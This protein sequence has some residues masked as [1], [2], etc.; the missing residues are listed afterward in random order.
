[1]TQQLKRFLFI[2]GLLLCYFGW[3]TSVSA[4]ADVLPPGVIIGDDSGIKVGEDGKYLIEHTDIKPGLQFNK[5]LTISN[6]SQE[7]GAFDV[8]LDMKS[9]KVSGQVN[10]LEAIEVTLTLEN[11]VIYQGNLAGVATDP[12]QTLPL[13]LGTYEVGEMGTL[14]AAFTV[15]DT[16]PET[17]WQKKNTADFYWVFYVTRSA[18][19]KPKPPVSPKKKPLL[20]FLPQ[21]G[22]EW[23]YVLIGICVGILLVCL[24]LIQLKRHQTPK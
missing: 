13:S 12:S 11:K 15:A 22:E 4:D 24:V 16:L 1:M 19:P 20:S 23:H 6:Y 5:Q 2:L 21:T 7:D 9:D 18:E 8:K 10:L 17:A 14:D 3:E